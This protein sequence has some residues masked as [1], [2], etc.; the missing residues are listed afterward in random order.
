VHECRGAI[1]AL[2]AGQRAGGV[3]RDIRQPNL[4]A[5]H[6]DRAEAAGKDEQDGGE[7]DGK[8][9][10]DAARVAARKDSAARPAVTPR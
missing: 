8:L 3:G 4:L 2:A 5:G 10:G 9:S 1:G 7:D 6:L